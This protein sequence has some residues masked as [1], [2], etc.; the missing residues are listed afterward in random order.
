VTIA[1]HRDASSVKGTR[2]SVSSNGRYLVNQ[3]GEPFLYLADTGWSMFK[4]LTHHE[5]DR[6]FRNRLAKGFTAI[7][8]Y[9]LRGL[10]VANPE[11]HF[12]LVD[13]D[14]TKLDEGFFRNVDYLV[15]RANELG[16]VMALVTCWGEHVDHRASDGRHDRRE[17]I[18]TTEN[19]F[20]YGE[21]LG[22]R[23]RD[24]CVI[25]LLGGDHAPSDETVAIWDAMARG[26]KA[27]SNGIH[28]VSYHASG[29]WSSSSHF[30]QHG[31]LDFNTIQSLHRSADPN[32]ELVEVD[33]GLLP[34]KPT[35]DMEC[36]YE[37][38]IDG[39]YGPRLISN[40]S[41]RIDARQ[42]REAAY[43]AVLAGAAGQAYGHNSVWQFHDEAKADGP[44]DYSDPPIPPTIGWIAAMDS[45]G[46]FGMSHL[47]KLLELRPWYQMV[48]DQSV[49]AAGQG[50]GE[51]HIQAARAED[52]SF[53]LA[54]LPFGQTVVMRMDKITGSP[55]RAQW[56]NPR[57]GTFTQIAEYPNTPD[58]R[59]FV[60]PTMG[61]GNDWVLVLEDANRNYPVGW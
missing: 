44:I 29:G 38:I 60:A 10:E 5:A 20:A 47:R 41:G 42:V 15:N 6:Y 30:H 50:E 36:R 54:Y 31:W 9:V 24:N 46:A 8:A 53:V 34:V 51:D 2:L 39:L 12:P 43:W 18:F 56:Y 57:A 13:R 48:P 1:Q 58:L 16:L 17:Q 59:E 22:A 28:L 52:G 27:G 55:V 26:L 21:I 23:Y 14:P 11:G 40:P 49:I 32:Y 61:E 19:A 4:R 35:L 37:D 33:Y 45:A 3:D 7:Q 25:W